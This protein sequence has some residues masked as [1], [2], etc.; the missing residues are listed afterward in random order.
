MSRNFAIGTIVLMFI[1]I[2]VLVKRSNSI[3]DERNSWRDAATAQTHQAEFWKNK[4]G[5]S[6]AQIQVSRGTYRVL[7]AQKDQ[8]LIRAQ[9]EISGLKS[10]LKNLQTIVAIH[11]TTSGSVTAV[12]RD[13][14]LLTPNT[15][16]DTAK[17]FSYSDRWISMNGYFLRDKTNITYSVL[18]EIDVVQYWKHP[19][20]KPRT[21]YTDVIS[22]N[23]NSKLTNLKSISLR[24]PT[25]SRFH[26]GLFVGVGTNLQ[27]ELG[28]GVMYSL[29]QF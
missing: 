11:S 24:E 4:N 20:L 14:V 8:D 25:L 10:N 5:E 12:L 16:P 29:I 7:L 2:L 15:P 18:D 13:T 26:L 27:P 1:A 9:K 3:S 22:R 17:S 19:F 21:L 28:V 23:P 6:E